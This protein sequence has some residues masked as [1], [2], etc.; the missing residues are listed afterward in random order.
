[1]KRIISS[2]KSYQSTVPNLSNWKLSPTFASWSEDKPNA[3]WI[4]SLEWGFRSPS[5]LSSSAGFYWCE[6]DE[7]HKE[8]WL[9]TNKDINVN[10]YSLKQKD[11]QPLIGTASQTVWLRP[12]KVQLHE[13]VVQ[14]SGEHPINKNIYRSLPIWSYALLTFI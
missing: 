3:L 7:R 6:L 14:P 4:T 1:M 12:S 13:K 5:Q 8:I 10:V 9:E 2:N 11:I